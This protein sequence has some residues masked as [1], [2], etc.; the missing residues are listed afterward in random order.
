[1]IK[2]IIYK[3][4]ILVILLGVLTSCLD[5]FDELRENPNQ[6]NSVPPSLIFT[7]LTP[8]A[9]ASFG[10][11]Y[12]RMQY[13]TWIATDNTNSPNFN[14]GFGGSFNYSSVRNI[15]KMNEEADKAG[16]PEYKILGKFYRARIYLEMTRRMGDIPLTESMQGVEIPQP[17][18]DTQKS[19]YLQGLNWLDE[20]NT[21]LGDFIGANPGKFI[22]GDVYFDGNLSKWQKIIN[23]YTLRILMSLSKKESDADLNIKGRF[24]GIVSNPAKYPLMESLLDNA[25]L[26]YSGEDGFKQTYQPEQA[27]RKDAVVYASTYIDIL[28]DNLDPRLMIVADPTKDA[29]EA[30]SDEAT[31]RADF[32]SYE[33]A[34]ISAPGA[35]NSSKKLDGDYSFPNDDKYWNFVG[36]PGIW[37]SYW[38]QELHIAEAANRGWTTADAKTHYDKGVTAS[39][40]WYGVDETE[41]TDYITNKQPYIAGAAGLTRVLEQKY[42][43]FAENSDQESFFTTRRTGVPTYIFSEENGIDPNLGE[44]YPIRWTYPGSE[45]DDNAINYRAA[46]IAQFG[47]EIDDRDQVI[48]LLKD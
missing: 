42:L 20:A 17:I 38:E 2:N 47:E 11:T 41:I 1:M 44:K 9:T 18:Y 23:S 12:E 39:M 14:S 13:H 21:E 3:S 15:E 31:V 5:D 40:R 37:M 19:V 34:D 43:A 35:D 29:L 26:E 28:K 10:G 6:P 32:D 4:T 8:G 45:D 46:L 48:W 36:Q 22:E 25:Q 33:G 30:G 7:D 24:E 16:A 27:V